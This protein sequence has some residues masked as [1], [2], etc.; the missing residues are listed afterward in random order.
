MTVEPLTV[1]LGDLSSLCGI[2]RL[3]YIKNVLKTIR[4]G[5]DAI[6][7]TNDAETW[8]TILNLSDN[9]GYEVVENRKEQGKYF[10]RI[11]VKA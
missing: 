2:S 9:L 5:Q 7:I 6:L 8:Y 4:P 1:D 11:R 10:V 3:T